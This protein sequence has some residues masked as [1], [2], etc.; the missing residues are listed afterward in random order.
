MLKL[1]MRSRQVLAKNSW[2]FFPINTGQ[3]VHIELFL[4]ITN[5]ESSAVNFRVTPINISGNVSN[6]STSVNVPPSFEV[7]SVNERNKGILVE[8]DGKVNVYGLSF[9]PYSADAYLALPCSKMAVD[10]YEYYGISYD[11]YIFPN[12]ILFV[13]CENETV[14]KFNS[15]TITLN[16]M[17][18]YQIASDHD[19]TGTR[20]TSSKPLSVFSGSDCA[21]VPQDINYCD[22]L[23]EQVP[24]TVTWGSKFLVAS[25]DGRSSG[26]RIRVLSA[27][28]AS[29]AVNCNTNVS[30][31]EFQLQSG[32]SFREFE[33]PI[34]SFCSIES[35]SP[36]LVTQYAYGR[37][38]DGV[39]D[40]FMMIIP[41]IEQFTNNYVIEAFLLF[42]GSNYVTVYV[43]SE[44][45]QTEQI[46]LDNSIVTGWRNV[47]CSSGE[48]CGH[49]SRTSVSTGAHSIRHQNSSA[50]LGV[51][52]YGFDTTNSYGYP[53]GMRLSPIQ[54][55]CGQNSICLNN[56]E[57]F[58]CSCL[59][60]FVASL[61]E[62]DEV[63]CT[64]ITCPPLTAPTNG[65][66]TYRCS[67]SDENGNYGFNAMANHSCD[68]GFVL[69]GNSTR[70]CTGDGSSTTGVF[71]GEAAICEPI[72]CPPLTAPT[73]GSVT[74]SSSTSDENGNYAF[75]AMANHSCYT[76]FVLVGNNTRT[77]TG[78]GSSTTGVFDGEAAICERVVQCEAE[79][80][81]VWGLV[82]PTTVAG[83]LYSQQC[84]Q[85]GN[86]I[87][88]GTAT[89]FCTLGGV[90]EAV[91]ID[92]CTREVISSLNDRA[93]ELFSR[94]ASQNNTSQNKVD[95]LLVSLAE[96]TSVNA[97]GDSTIFPQDLS[98]TNTIVKSSVNYLVQNV[99]I[100]SPMSS[101]NF[102]E[103]VI[104]ILNNVLDKRNTEGWE[105]L[106]MDST[107]ESQQLLLNA[108][109]YGQY[110]S[111]ALRSEAVDT[112]NMTEITLVRQNI[113]LAA[114]K[115]DTT[116]LDDIIFPEVVNLSEETG[117][118]Q[119]VIPAALL[120]ERG[121]LD[122]NVIAVN[123][124][125]SNLEDFLPKTNLEMNTTR[126][127]SQV[128]SSQVFSNVKLTNSQAQAT[129]N[130]TTQKFSEDEV[131]E[132][133]KCVFW[134]VSSD[135]ANS[136]W[137]T[138]GVTTVSMD[139]DKQMR[140][141]NIVCESSHFTA[142]A[143]LMD[144]TGA[145]ND[146]TPEIRFALSV[147][148]YVG[149]SIS[150]FFLLL[151]ILYF[152]T[153]RKE[154]LTKVHNFIHLNLSISL[155]LG[156]VVFLSGVETAVASE[157][158]CA[159]VAALLHYLFTTVFFWMLC[160][161]IM[162]YLMLVLVFNQISKKWW[163]FFIIGW[164]VPVIPVAISAALIHDQY[165]T[166]QYCWI[167]IGAGDKGAIWAFVVPMLLVVLVNVFFLLAAL[168]SVYNQR[169]STM[170]RSG[171]KE[172]LQ[173]FSQLFKAT[174]ILLPLLG[175]TWMFGLLSVNSSTIVFAWLF[176]IFNSLQGLFVFIFHVLRSEK[177]TNFL[178]Q[179]RKRTDSVVS[180]SASGK[181]NLSKNPTS[182]VQL[183]PS[184]SRF[185][186][187][188][189]STMQD[190][191]IKVDETAASEF[192]SE[193]S[194]IAGLLEY[195]EEWHK[196]MTFNWI[197]GF[198][199]SQ[200]SLEARLL[201]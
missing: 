100:A 190:E 178:K 42:R 95:N 107:A 9:E 168:R 109:L 113:V 182:G 34:N 162:L 196:T 115:V 16:S 200:E 163:I 79:E 136:T 77:C 35:T 122:G 41:P 171:K 140:V 24:P 98:T 112:G 47:V 165:G 177:V 117:S 105:R 126:P 23:V 48:I 133:A 7:L 33:I 146:T 185:S 38:S 2:F 176:S 90:W 110:V 64:A 32:G 14:V 157:V 83:F 22:H 187:H 129:F 150:I 152:L 31:S 45:F 54:C 191:A 70:T 39:G 74:Y 151:S 51:S 96:A 181:N 101:L 56:R 188:D 173:L 82:F 30:V 145:L 84:P 1:Q 128:I 85:N 184:H 40:P 118:A 149:C 8:A 26:E 123:I 106:Q 50:I 166:K 52:V 28:A 175:L 201:T 120:M 172:S 148:T 134:S 20:I 147:V 53:G 153:L 180:T 199:N 92:N 170:Q 69:V 104:N 65:F 139:E 76:G 99:E 93:N 158:A 44:F 121:A 194:Y 46:L 10:E 137:S 160:E 108:E 61:S 67:T 13:A 60:E 142:F 111:L 58:N 68:T 63:V 125:F 116:S 97:T 193:K 73:N 27:R 119:T 66:V 189:H 75:N 179:C 5:P 192:G 169:K 138:E 91:N 159:F 195:D 186:K 29:V 167:A 88:L 15:S 3:V 18:T 155:L 25:L 11:I 78:D 55:N 132:N 174:I 89:R 141:Y 164:V 87:T 156:Y 94:N 131:A 71:D 12:V 80:D 161:G 59:N 81:S 197:K 6:S 19:L 102:S 21:S 127:V 103:E 57:Q 183:K 72:T 43:S 49:I 130:F 124:L 36:V 143:V 37:E 198:S 86:G 4:F 135:A 154:L 144:V 114:I 62:T 17:E